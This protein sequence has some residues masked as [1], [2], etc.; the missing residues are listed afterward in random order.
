M[1]VLIVTKLFL[2]NWQVWSIS[3]LSEIVS[4]IC[5]SIDKA[6]PS[7]KSFDQTKF[8]KTIAF[9]FSESPWIPILTLLESE[10]AYWGNDNLRKNCI[11][12]TKSSIPEQ[13]PTSLYLL[14]K[15]LSTGWTIGGK[16]SG[17]SISVGVGWYLYSTSIFFYS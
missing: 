2:K 7:Q 8:C 9:L 3:V 12:S 1:S 17:I 6:L 13:M 10:N 4:I 14:D 5:S 15:G 11:I 16:F